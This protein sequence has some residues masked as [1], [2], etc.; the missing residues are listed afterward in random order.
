MNNARTTTRSEYIYLGGSLVAQRDTPT[1][2]GT[3]TIKYQ[4]TDALGTPVAVTDANRVVIERSEYE[5]Y[6][7]LLN[8]PIKDGPGFTGHVQDAQSGLTYMQQRYY[9]PMLGR[10]LS[11]D[12][13]TATS[14]G[15]NFTRYWYANNNP[16]RF[17]D[18][19]G[20][21]GCAAS[22]IESACVTGT[23][24]AMAMMATS[25]RS[26]S[27]FSADRVGGVKNSPNVAKLIRDAN[28]VVGMANRSG[29]REFIDPLNSIK[30]LNI[31]EA[32][33]PK[34]NLGM[35]AGNAMADYA[36]KTITFFREYFSA[37]IGSR[38]LR[39]IHETYHLTER[40]EAIRLKDP[41]CGWGCSRPDNSERSTQNSA[42]DFKLKW[43]RPEDFNGQD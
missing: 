1:V 5:P 39:F 2:G 14:T 36:T 41:E 18:P 23:G 11:V 22:R 7:Q 17:T 21:F 15:G 28:R 42:L 31:S 25:A 3:S 30:S 9:D 20:R 24:A 8:R 38:T 29:D 40:M 27:P 35:P 32:S 37:D 4:H 26:A 33:A 34:P 12:P 16:Y 6:G 19:D 43:Q 10:F 13:V